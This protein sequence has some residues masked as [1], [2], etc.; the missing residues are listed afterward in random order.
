MRVQVSGVLEV[1]RGQCYTL[2]CLSVAY[3]SVGSWHWL[4]GIHTR[5]GLHTSLVEILQC[6]SVGEGSV[7]V[8]LS[9]GGS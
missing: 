4:V 3:L 6:C 9:V 5:K 1:V 8:R 7:R 2:N